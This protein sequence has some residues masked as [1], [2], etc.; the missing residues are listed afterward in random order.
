MSKKI[1]D[2]LTILNCGGIIELESSTNICAAIF[3][4]KGGIENK[5]I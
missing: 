2:C 4:E 1:K 3:L 5:N